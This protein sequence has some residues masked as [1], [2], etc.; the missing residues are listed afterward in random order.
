VKNAVDDAVDRCS[1]VFNLRESIEDAR[2]RA[3]Q[4]TDDRQKKAHL[5]K[6]EHS[7]GMSR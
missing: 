4:A 5:N 3:E 1:T 6:G 7:P 2:V